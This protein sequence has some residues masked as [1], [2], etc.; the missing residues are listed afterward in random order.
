VS[1]ASR[2]YRVVL[3]LGGGN[4]LGAF[5]AGVYEQLHGAGLLPDWIIGA[6]VGAI[7][8]AM[9]AGTAPDERVGALRSFWQPGHAPDGDDP[10]SWLMRATEDSRRTLASTWGLL[11]GRPGLFG[12]VLSSWLPWASERPALYNTEQMEATLNAAVDFE[13]LNNGPCRYTATAVDLATSEDVVFD[14]RDRTI[15]AQ[16]IRA[17]A[18]LPVAFPPVEIDGRWLIDGGMSA[19]LPVDPF[20][21]EPSAEPTLCIAV[22]LLPLAQPLPRTL[23]EAAGRMQDVIFAAQTRRS[24]VRWRAEMASNEGA[25]VSFVRLAYVEQEEEVAGKAMDYS[26]PTVRRRWDAGAAAAE[27]LLSALADNTLAI[28]RPG[29]HVHQL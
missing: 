16:H 14:S 15:A 1:A 8:G 20:F 21:A 25:A 7:N 22:D 19:N 29:L 13:R 26:G 9:I 2:N 17:S 6:S 23:G 4:A 27:R 24:L 10:W 12:P 11:A 3:I 5:E 18:A 28:G